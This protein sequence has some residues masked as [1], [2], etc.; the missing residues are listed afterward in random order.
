MKEY[1]MM[2]AFVDQ[3]EDLMNKMAKEGWEVVS[4]AYWNM[5]VAKLLITFSREVQ[6]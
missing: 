1:K 5:F 4:T 2:E 3:A 6:E